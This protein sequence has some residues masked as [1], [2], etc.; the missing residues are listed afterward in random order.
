MN[1][2]FWI[3]ALIAFINSL[4]LTILIPIIY[5]YGKRFGLSDFETSLLFSM[6]SVAQFLATPVIGK[7][8]DRFGRKPL[9]IISLA[10]TV[11]ANLIAGNATTAGVLFFA[12]FLDGI[13]GGNA[14]VAQAIISDVTTAENRARGF[15]FYGAAFG[16][17]FVLGPVTSL[18][19]QQISLGTAF[20]VSGA[21]AFVGLLVTIFLLPETLQNKSKKAENIF[22]LGLGNLISGLAMPKVGV[23]LVIN[24]FIGTTF[25]I[26]TFALQPYFINVLGQ[27][28]Q[29]LTLMF[30]VVGVLGVIM[31]TW[32]VSVLS[33][34][35]NIVN[36]LFL[37]LFVRSLSFVLMPIWE[38]IIYFVVVAILFSLFNS[39]VQPMINTLIS[40][41]AKAEDQGTAMGLNASYLSISNGIGPVIAGTLIHQSNPITYGYP[42][43]LAGILTFLVLFLAI[44]TREKYAL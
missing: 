37:S 25:T 44:V 6:Y 13:T 18:F 12:R 16:L 24:F 38:N 1:R 40:L 8:S 35:F 30:L 17:G 42:L 34:K 10:G 29:S 27:N 26:F 28:S 2:N 43:Y 41:N 5:I 11:I 14:S 31:Q 4:S 36:I 9:L 3:T 23:L 32:G 20:L 7:L 15:G 22:D 39:L 21:V 19:A 33:R